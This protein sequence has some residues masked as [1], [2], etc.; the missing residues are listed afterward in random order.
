[1]FI[2]K[3]HEIF[4]P[5]TMYVKN[6]IFLFLEE[7]NIKLII[8]KLIPKEHKVKIESEDQILK[9]LKSIP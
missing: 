5:Y 9:L 6:V 7:Q 8:R 4:F 1:M 3:R 2:M